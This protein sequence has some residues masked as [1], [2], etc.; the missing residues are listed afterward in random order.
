MSGMDQFRHNL[1][2]TNTGVGS[3][4]HL[5]VA[6]SG[7]VVLLETP[8]AVMEEVAFRATHVTSML[9]KMFEESKKHDCF[10]R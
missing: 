8:E 9:E 2:G 3:H 1:S 10:W 4:A 6:E 5:L 7:G